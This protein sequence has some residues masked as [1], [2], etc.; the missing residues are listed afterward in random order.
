MNLETFRDYCLQKDHVE[1]T[2]PFDDTTLAFKVNNKMFATTSL[3][4]ERN[5]S[6]NLKCEPNR[7]LELRADLMGVIPGF[8]SNKKHWN[9]VSFNLDVSDQIIY[10]LIDHSYD[11]VFR[12]FSKKVQKELS[13]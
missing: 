7:A 4:G 13:E 2:F 9:T 11:L 6:C 1:E 5:N 10:E 3:K 12:S 8:H